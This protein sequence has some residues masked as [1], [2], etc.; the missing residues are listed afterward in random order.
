[1]VAPLYILREADLLAISQAQS[2][3]R[4]VIGAAWRNPDAANSLGPD[5]LFGVGSEMALGRVLHMPQGG[6]SVLVQ[7]RRRLE[8]V[9]YLQTEPYGRVRARPIEE[10]VEQSRD[11]T[12]LMRATV[13]LFQKCAA[14]PAHP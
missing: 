13:N 6:T 12:A 3:A 5:A 11:G 1:M 8:I 2:K 9:D 14:Q 10:V 4:T 7:G